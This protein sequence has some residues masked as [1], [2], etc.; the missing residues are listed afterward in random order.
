MLVEDFQ[1]Q[2]LTFQP[3]FLQALADDTG[4]WIVKGF[5][6]IHQ[7]IYTISVDT[8]VLSKIIELLIFPEV[9]L[10][11][12]Q[13]DYQ[14]VLTEHQNHYPD[15]T[16]IAKDGTKFAIDF[17]STY[18]ISQTSVSGF[19]LGSFTG[20]FRNR[21]STKNIT[22]PYEDYA[23]HFVIGTIYTR[24]PDIDERQTFKLSE[25]SKIQSVATDF[26]VLVREKWRIASDKPGSGNTKNIGSIKSEAALIAGNGT[27]ASYSKKVFDDYW[28][29]YLT[30]DMARAIESA[31]P[32][33]NLK[34]YMDWLN[35]LS[36]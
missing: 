28:V 16:L 8:K 32:Y 33:K 13:Y 1:K 6:D 35:S 3:Q 11:A 30:N 21:K 5:I 17:K 20:Y 19:T 10:F 4:D 25:L 29:N 15:V 14:F 9:V 31:V 26:S 24:V 23:G 36:G 18:R 34:S 22:F 2:L 7:K 27:F 12:N